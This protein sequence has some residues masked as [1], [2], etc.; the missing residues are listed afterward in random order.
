MLAQN[1]IR[2]WSFKMEYCRKNHLAPTVAEAW[3]LAEIAYKEYGMDKLVNALQ[4]LKPIEQEVLSNSLNTLIDID[5]NPSGSVPWFEA[6]EI[7]LEADEVENV[8]M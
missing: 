2:K 6:D 7:G 4:K 1:N 3:Q 8:K 5:M